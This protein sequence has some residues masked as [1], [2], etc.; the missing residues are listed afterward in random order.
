MRAIEFLG[1]HPTEI[2]VLCPVALRFA[3]DGLL[4]VFERLLMHKVKIGAAGDLAERVD[5]GEVADVVIA[6]L[7]ATGEFTSAK[8]MKVIVKTDKVS[9]QQARL[10]PLN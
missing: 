1:T 3:M 5:S 10:A 6:T 8:D 7:K 2:R 4:L 9:G